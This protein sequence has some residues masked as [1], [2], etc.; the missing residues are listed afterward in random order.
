MNAREIVAGLSE[1]SF[2]TNVDERDQKVWRIV[3]TVVAGLVVGFFAAVAAFLLV[4]IV[5][6]ATLGSI[7]DGASAF[8]AFMAGLAN[9]DGHDLGQA[10]L[11][12]FMPTLANGPLV[13][14][15]IVLAGAL[16]HHQMRDYLTSAPRFRWR[17]L[18]AGMVMSMLAIGPLLGLDALVTGQVS[19]MPVVTVSPTLA[20]RVVYGASA[21]V[22]LI[23]AALIEEVLFRGWLL[24]QAAAFLRNPWF[25]MI[26][27]GVAFSAIHLDFNP[28]AFLARTV[29]G[30]GFAYM[31]LRL[32][33][34]EFSTGAHAANNILIVMFL[35]PL[36]LKAPPAA[37]MSAESL[38][39]DLLLAAG[40][41]LITEAVVRIPWLKRW[42][43]VRD[44]ELGG[45]HGHAAA[46]FG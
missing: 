18:L 13:V 33:G 4:A 41:V 8:G 21:I 5:F 10:I 32:G 2:L 37:G 26:F 46:L 31:T 17:L 20:G 44:Q 25:L 39:Q 27:T 42:T 14:T 43:E 23:P 24:R 3:L 22:L 12:L 34:L 38:V 11:L 7:P 19:P 1:S 16:S 40:Y 15:F 9:A 45:D 6:M 36:T 30:A 35:E 28:D 29:M